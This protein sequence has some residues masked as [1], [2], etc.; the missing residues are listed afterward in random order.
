MKKRQVYFIISLLL[1]LTVIALLVTGSSLLTLALD[2]DN[3]VPLGTFITWIGM[4]SLPLSIYWGIKAL[5][6]PTNKLHKMLSII[7]KIVII[8]GLLWIPISYLLAGNLSFT[9]SEKETFQGRQTAMRWFWYLSY[10]IGI[11]ALV[12]LILYWLTLLFK[13]VSH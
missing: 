5:R 2:N 4:F 12:N 13:K 6:K 1:T 9:F 11:G 8:L 7:L 10:G 3:T